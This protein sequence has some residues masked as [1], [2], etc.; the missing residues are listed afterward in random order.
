M[1]PETLSIVYNSFFLYKAFGIAALHIFCREYIFCQCEICSVIIKV[2]GV[3]VQNALH[4]FGPVLPVMQVSVIR[5][6]IALKAQTG[7]GGA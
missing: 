2:F 4:K 3:G 7:G 6:D 5:L 1:L